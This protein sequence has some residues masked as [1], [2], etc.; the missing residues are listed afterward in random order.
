MPRYLAERAAAA[1]KGID[2]AF[3]RYAAARKTVGVG[4]FLDQEGCES[5]QIGIYGMSIWLLLT[6]A[7]ANDANVKRLREECAQLLADATLGIAPDNNLGDEAIKRALKHTDELK[8][9]VPKMAYACAALFTVPARHAAATTLLDRLTTAQRNGG[10]GFTTTATKPNV[11]PTALVARLLRGVSGREAILDHAVTYLRSELGAVSNPYAKLFVLNAIK[12]AKEDAVQAR[13]IAA[14]ISDLYVQVA[15]QPTK[16]PNPTIVDY[17]DNARTRY[18]RIPSDVLLIESLAFL[19]G[20]WQLYLSAHTG[21]RVFDYLVASSVSMETF[22][23]DATG[24]RAAMELVRVR[25]SSDIW[26]WL[27]RASGW[28]VSSTKFG[29]DFTWNLVLLLASFVA[30][31]AFHY[32]D[33][34]PARNVA[35]GIFAKSL[36]DGIRSIYQLRKAP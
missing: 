27:A 4:Q 8:S 20:G 32:Y 33:N 1:I 36:S 11:M 13:E 34:Q 24:H 7:V 16:F 31:V 19:G 22:K 17:Q 25:Q 21:R 15:K 26:F 35:G 3:I 2:T 29:V 5:P 30:G 12:H 6:S 18:F 28:F 9:I 10:W 14:A 23:V